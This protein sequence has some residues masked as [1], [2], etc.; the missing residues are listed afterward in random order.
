MIV[1]F[2]SYKGGTGRTMALA[3]VAALLAGRGHRVLAVDFDLEAPG[4]WRY[5][6]RFN[7]RLD[8]QPGLID[9][10]AE[11]FT[12]GGDADWRDYVTHLPVKQGSLTL[13]TSG[14]LVE[15][16]A[17]KVLDFGWT[18]FFQS[19]H[20]GDFLEQL[21]RKWQA[22][23]DFTL[24]DSRT[25]VTDSGGVCTIMF[26]D[27]IV[28]VFVSN[29]QSIDGAVDVIGR[30]QA[31]RKKLAYDRPPAAIL[32]IFSRFESRAEY[33]TAQRW[34]DI[35]AESV[36]P[37]YSDW[38]PSRLGPRRALEKTKL[39]YVTYFSF[40]EQMPALMDS[41]SDPESLGYALNIVSLLIEHKLENAELLLGDA[42]GVGVGTDPGVGM[43]QFVNPYTFV[44]HVPE[45]ERKPPVGHAFLGDG[46]LSGVLKVTLTA[47]TPLLIGGYGRPDQEGCDIPRRKDGI[48][49][50][51]G[52]GVLG[53]VRSLHEALAGGCLRVLNTD[54]VPVHRHPASTSVTTDVDLRLA[55][56][57]KVDGDGRAVR[58]ALCEEWIWIPSQLLPRGE[59]RLPRTGDRLQYHAESGTRATLPIPALTGTRERRVLN[60][61][62]DKHPE[63]VVLGSITWVDE[64]GG[65]SPDWWVLLITDTNARTRGPDRKAYFAAG[66]I[67]SSAPSYDV[68][69]VTWENFSKTVEGAD[70]LRPAELVKAGIKSGKEPAYDPAREPDYAD[71]RWP[72]QDSGDTIGQRLL[73][74]SYLHEGQPIW[75]QV[76]DR[77]RTVTELR[78][79]ELWRY[80][81]DG[82]V[83]DRV[84]SAAPCT[85]PDNLCWSCRLFGS[86]DTGGRD[87]TDLAVQKSYRG[88]VRIDDLLAQG[89][90]S[91]L[92]WHLAPLSSPRPSAGQ[93]YLD[94]TGLPRS[95]RLSAKDTKPAA[96]WGSEADNPALRPIRGRKF[97]WRTTDPAGGDHPRGQF[98]D[99]QSQTLGKWVA[100]I[101]AGTV[102]T[103]NVCFDNVNPADLGSLLV[104]LDP[105]LMTAIQP[106]WDA[107]KI[108][109][110]I[111]GG[112]PFGFGSVTIDVELVAAQTAQARYLGEP[113]QAV[114]IPEAV[115]A[116]A[117][118]ISAPARIAWQ[119]LSHVLTSGFVPDDLVWYPPGPGDKGTMEYDQSFE[120]FAHSNGIAMSQENRELVVLPDVAGSAASQVLE[121][122]PERRVRRGR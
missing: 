3:N 88:H 17:S 86:A 114:T 73:A 57:T 55:V 46:Q 32:P 112:K 90:V 75:V 19:A 8:Q 103:G 84:G 67:S 72:P 21:R 9:L 52:S 63:G 102:F 91:K 121:S 48:A 89:H 117:G 13:M 41:I 53:A 56:V 109:T 58:V 33:E 92:T 85:D 104:A 16:Y 44:Q 29:Y 98:R 39:P 18:E 31:A 20:G 25:G 105:R 10:L 95:K 94:Q 22:T 66:R 70:D 78:L 5:F 45:P 35:A 37:F 11:A 47:R 6:T 74:R 1:T 69:S 30:A 36:G 43:A 42:V 76:N 82:P 71:V 40:G 101:P 111:G 15:G 26:P 12:R 28:P 64:M 115:R 80:Q 83:G 99:H 24:I 51:P 2:Y 34:L 107:E 60:A 49:M 96:T 4:L 118:K 68:P 113:A 65:D 59:D 108:V 116:F 81:G 61:R 106:G 62:S 97:Y 100:L 14:R 122:E 110:S 23:F 87:K 93:F 7:D 77:D 54:F 50:V 79:S 27:M 38:L 120:F 119:E